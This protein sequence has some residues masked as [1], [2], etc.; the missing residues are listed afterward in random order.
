MF[1]EI[2]KTL[3]VQY[4]TSFSVIGWDDTC[5]LHTLAEDSNGLKRI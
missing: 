3:F 1:L 2:S 5:G 4:V